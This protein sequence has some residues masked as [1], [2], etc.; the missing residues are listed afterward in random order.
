MLKN[1]RNSK[2]TLSG[3]KKTHCYR[4]LQ[5]LEEKAYIKLCIL[6]RS[7]ECKGLHFVKELENCVVWKNWRNSKATLSAKNA[8]CYRRL[9]CWEEKAC[10]KPCIKSRSAECRRLHFVKKL[11]DCVVWKNCCIYK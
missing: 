6:W 9:H 4:R 3:R 10:I 11:E 5:C 8:H 7:A 1:G 2:T